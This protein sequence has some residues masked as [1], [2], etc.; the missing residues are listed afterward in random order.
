MYVNPATCQIS[1][2]IQIANSQKRLFNFLLR[3]FRFGNSNTNVLLKI[4]NIKSM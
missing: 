4:Q 2:K 1:S 3:Y